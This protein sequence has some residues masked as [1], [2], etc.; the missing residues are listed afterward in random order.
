MFQPYEGQSVQCDERLDGA[1]VIP[2]PLRNPGSLL[3]D[4]WLPPPPKAANPSLRMREFK[5]SCKA[6]AANYK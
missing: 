6:S 3:V 1:F 4:D 5:L 2:R